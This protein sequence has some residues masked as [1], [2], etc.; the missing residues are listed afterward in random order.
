MYTIPKKLLI[1]YLG[2]LIVLGKINVGLS[3]VGI[4]T[5]IISSYLLTDIS[6]YIADEKTYS[7]KYKNDSKSNFIGN[8]IRHHLYL[9]LLIMDSIIFKNLPL[10]FN[11]IE[12]DNSLIEYIEENNQNTNHRFTNKNIDF[13]YNI[14]VDNII[15]LFLDKNKL[16]KKYIKLSEI[17]ELYITNC[18]KKPSSLEK[19]VDNYHI[20]GHIPNLFGLNT[21]RILIL[22]QKD[23]ND[24]SKTCFKSVKVPDNTNIII[25][26]YNGQ[27]HKA[28]LDNESDFICKNRVLLKLH[29]IT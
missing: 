21:Y 24:K 8:K 16:D 17:D 28:D 26:D 6:H 9:P 20:D 3:S 5:L 1:L 15:K 23:K 10:Y 29:F 14:N 27:I 25:F 19:V 18:K 7:S 22:L 4:Y 12:I 2:I 13:D 11:E